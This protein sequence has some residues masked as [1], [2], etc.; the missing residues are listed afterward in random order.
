MYECN[1][2]AFIVEQ[3]GGL[4]FDGVQRIMDIEC[5]SIHQ[6]VPL[7]IGSSEMVKKACSMYPNNAVQFSD[8]RINVNA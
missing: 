6:R 4:A 3:A 1:P 7:L 8:S 2:L 5:T